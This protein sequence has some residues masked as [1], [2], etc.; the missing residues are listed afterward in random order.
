MGSRPAL[1]E[2]QLH[3][4]T[5]LV[6]ADGE[7][8][9]PDSEK[10]FAALGDRDPDYDAIGYAI[11]N[12]GFIKFQVLD[13]LVA[14]IEL[15]PRNVDLRALLAVER[16]LGESSAKLFR[17]KYLENEWHS[18]ISSNAEHTLARL[19]E[20]C[21]PVFNP[22][23]NE[24]FRVEPQ[25]PAKLFATHEARTEGLGPM[26]M[27]WRVAFGNFDLGVMS[28]A[29]SS[30][31]ISRMVIVGF[32]PSGGR[33]SI[34]FFGDAHGW[35]SSS[36]RIEGIGR[37]I[38][39]LPDKEYGA[40]LTKFYSSVA[41]GGQPRYDLV[42][43]QLEYS[44]EPGRPRRQRVYERLLLPWRTPSDG[45]LVTSCVKLADDR[46]A[47]LRPA[48]SASTSVKNVSKSP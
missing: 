18:E 8:V 6:T 13:R 15:H 1:Q 36:Y 48:G 35:V 38:E 28:I 16:L 20:L 21:A 25:D 26:A 19:H 23:P 9:L 27:K 34:R 43:A 14:E 3:Q 45:V 33:S 30:K 7:C 42:T 2:A 40:W 12:L 22:P 4:L 46:G 37:S 31:L 29:D 17:I 24:R 44:R 5:M 32:E 10:F 41:E 39:D 47:N 11:R